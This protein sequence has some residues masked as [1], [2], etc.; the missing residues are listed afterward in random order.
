[1][2]TAELRAA[3]RA[4]GWTNSLLETRTGYAHGS[5]FQWLDGSA[6]IPRAVA[7]WVAMA[8]AWHLAHPAPVKVRKVKT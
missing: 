6:S 2:T 5:A 1:M 4:I 8:A 7:E 3:I